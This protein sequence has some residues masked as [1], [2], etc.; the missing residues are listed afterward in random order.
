MVSLKRKTKVIISSLLIFINLALNGAN[1]PRF[2]TLTMERGLLHTDVTC[3]TQ[4]V[5]GLIWIGTNGG[6]QSFDGYNLQT[7]DYYKQTDRIRYLH[8]RI[9]SLASDSCSLWIGTE[10]GLLRFNYNQGNYDDFE[11]SADLQVLSSTLVDKV[12]ATEEG[13]LWVVTSD[14]MYV[15]KVDRKRNL[16]S[17]YGKE[18]KV[19][20]AKRNVHTIVKNGDYTW[21][22]TPDILLQIK[23]AHGRMKIVNSYKC[24][25]ISRRNEASSSL[26]IRDNFL[27]LRVSSGCA[28]FPLN[29]DGSLNLSR[30]DFYDFH[31]LNTHIPQNT[32]GKLIVDRNN[33]LWCASNIGLLQI[34]TNSGK[35]YADIHARQSAYTTSIS[36]NFI[37]TLF[38]DSF[39]NLWIGTWGKGLNYVSLSMPC[40]VLYTIIPR[41]NIQ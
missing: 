19:L 13:V 35:V 32:S 28:R 29:T 1:V 11:L 40:L 24:R 34:S 9:T 21:L 14:S 6:L 3:V 33:T 41:M 5:N 12:Y 16:L 10:S 31:S 36:S 2:R 20:S 17:S 25:E 22:C 27:Y 38:I 7:Y 18:S 15:V 23:L 39:H 4:D 37:S 8:D 30:Y 26:Y